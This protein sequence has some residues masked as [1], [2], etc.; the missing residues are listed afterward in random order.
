MNARHIQLARAKRVKRIG[1]KVARLQTKISK[2]LETHDIHSPD[3]E[4]MRE[5]LSVLK[6]AARFYDLDPKDQLLSENET[7]RTAYREM[8][9]PDPLL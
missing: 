6:A 1:G 7:I 5:H 9:Y 8:G 2:M 3:I 4:Q